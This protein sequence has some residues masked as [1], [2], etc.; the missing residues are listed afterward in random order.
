MKEREY[1]ARS[2]Q[3]KFSP[4]QLLELEDDLRRLVDKREKTT[5]ELTQELVK[6]CGW[7]R[8]KVFGPRPYVYETLE[9]LEKEG[10][11][12]SRYKVVDSGFSVVT[13]WK[14]T[15]QG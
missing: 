9:D 5:E 14:I 10:V 12:E 15:S 6:N 13:Y 7:K 8:E 2:E 4:E 1:R 11:I 3:G